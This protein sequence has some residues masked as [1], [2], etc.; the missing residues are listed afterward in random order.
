MPALPDGRRLPRRS[1]GLRRST[2]RIASGAIGTAG[3]SGDILLRGIFGF[4]ANL[5]KTRR[6]L[7]WWS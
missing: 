2:T 6:E 7:A 1:D 4:L 3:R 5:R